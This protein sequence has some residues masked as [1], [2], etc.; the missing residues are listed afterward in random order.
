MIRIEFQKELEA[1]HQDIIRM[2]ATTEAAINDAV[3]ALLNMDAE[4]AKKVI[5]G[6]DVIDDMER[7]ID[8]KCVEIIARQQPV[9]KD[10]RDITSTLKLITDLERIADH[11]SDIS[12]RV[13]AIHAHE[14]RIP[15]PYDI[16][17][18][19]DLSRQMLRG[20]L[21]SYVTRNR[22]RAES[23]IELDDDVDELYESVKTYL[24]HL[25]K[26]DTNNVEQLVEL[27]LVIKYF[28]RIADH[29]Q[30]VAEWVLFYVLGKHANYERQPQHERT[31]L[32]GGGKT[33]E[34]SARKAKENTDDQAGKSDNKEI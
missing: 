3:I 27:L 6:D 7:E 22:E 4:L 28:E 9:A 24:I 32:A 19:A 15:V 23:I 13:I 26:V 21:D 16:L 20:A 34:D 10:L 1:L 17:R 31:A 2:G 8:R 11:A 25:M 14:D 18:M 12:E 29:A 30:N 33:A 5:A